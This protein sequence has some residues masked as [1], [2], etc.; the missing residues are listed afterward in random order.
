M[1]ILQRIAKRM[2]VKG[3][4]AECG[5]TTMLFDTMEAAR[6]WIHCQPDYLKEPNEM[7]TISFGFYT[8]MIVR[9][10]A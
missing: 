10:P 4:L 5:G 6:N 2:P 8:H 7:P 1:P 3:F 9:C